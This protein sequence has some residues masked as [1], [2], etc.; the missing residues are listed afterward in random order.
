[1]IRISCCPAGQLIYWHESRSG[2]LDTNF[3]G[4]GRLSTLLTSVKTLCREVLAWNRPRIETPDL[5][6]SI[7]TMHYS[8]IVNKYKQILTNIDKSG[9]CA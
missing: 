5:G 1:M 9:T 3:S 4:H 8:K 2:V 6:W 7:R